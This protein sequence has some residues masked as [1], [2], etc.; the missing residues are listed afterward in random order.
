MAQE[1]EE[2]CVH[3]AHAKLNTGPRVKREAL[4]RRGRGRGSGR[5]RGD[6]PMGSRPRRLV[7]RPSSPKQ[8]P[9]STSPQPATSYRTNNRYSILENQ[10]A[11]VRVGSSTDEDAGEPDVRLGG[12]AELSHV[13]HA[14]RVDARVERDH[15]ARVGEHDAEQEHIARQQQPH[16]TLC[17]THTKHA[18]AHIVHAST[19]PLLS[20]QAEAEYIG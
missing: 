2:H 12:G 20:S 9:P 5:G 17:T 10:L 14:G 19:R 4:G 6:A 7:K 15:E 18:I 11:R 8:R 3:T 1:A 13:A 16:R